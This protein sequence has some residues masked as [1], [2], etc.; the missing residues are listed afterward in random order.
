MITRE[1]IFDFVGASLATPAGGVRSGFFYSGD[2]RSP[3]A[4]ADRRYSQ[5]AIQ[6]FFVGGVCNPANPPQLLRGVANPA[7]K[8]PAAAAAPS[9]MSLPPSSVSVASNFKF[10][11]SL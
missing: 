5:P 11:V 9:E 10:Q 3:S 1:N 6:P 2:L 4:V 7:H 8:K